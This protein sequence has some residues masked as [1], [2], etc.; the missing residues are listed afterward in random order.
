[1]PLCYDEILADNSFG[2]IVF[3]APNINTTM[4][5]SMTNNS[6]ISTNE[7]QS[8]SL[9][10]QY[11]FSLDNLF[12]IA[13]HFLKEKQGSK[14]MQLKY[15]ENLHF[16]ALSKQATIGKWDASYTQNVGLLD[17]VG[18]DRKQAWI[19]LGDMSKEQAKEEYIKLLLERCPMFK[20]HL[21]AHHVESE[22]KDRLKREDEARRLLEQEAQ[23]VKQ[24]ELEQVSRLEEQKKKR[25]EFQ[26]KQIQ[27]ALNQQT[28]PQ[29]KAYAEQQFKDNRQA[30][31]ELI[32][33]L[34]EQHFQQYMQQIY[35]QQLL[36]QQQQ[37]RTK[38]NMEQQSTTLPSINQMQPL[39]SAPTQLPPVLHPPPQSF[40]NGTNSSDETKIE[41]TVPIQTQFESLSLNASLQPSARNDLSQQKFPSV[42]MNN[43]Y[44]GAQQSIDDHP[45]DNDVTINPTNE[46]SSEDGTREYPNLAPASMWTRKD[47]KEFKDAVR[48]EKDAVIKIGSGETVTVRVPTHEDGRCIFWEFAT[49]YYDIGFG[50]YFEWS[51]VQSN[52]V[53]V[54]VSDSSEDEED[55]GEDG[56]N[57]EK[58]DIEKGSRNS[59]KPPKPYQDEIVPIFRRDSHEEIYAGSHPYPGN[60][61]YLLKFDNSYSL[62]RSKTLYYRVY[63]SR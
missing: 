32:R 37:S 50:L 30:Q 43:E 55:E 36:N 31:D 18:N 20:P 9:T 61:V 63:Y 24:Y 40:A 38:P 26:R 45:L 5:S 47:I 57:Q 27:D 33:Q 6:D 60:G 53:T 35:Q 15:G 46:L 12:D 54:H 19:A 44:S 39:G 8:L 25:E 28:Y 21:E 4:S 23:R 48:K 17:V 22:E 42:Q 41:P 13:R 49:D 62:W 59:N 56:T 10:E 14:A 7:N 29:F 11:G 1:M 2:Q 51:Q 3:V 52:T 16:V 34:Q 58:K